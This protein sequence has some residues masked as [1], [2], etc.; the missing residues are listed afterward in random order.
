MMEHLY[1]IPAMFVLAAIG[2]AFVSNK[3]DQR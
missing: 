1:F 2:M 3:G